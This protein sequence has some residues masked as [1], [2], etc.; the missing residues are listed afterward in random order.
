MRISRITSRRLSPAIEADLEGLAATL[1]EMDKADA[2]RGIPR[3]PS[4]NSWTPHW[5]SALKSIRP[6]CAGRLSIAPILWRSRLLI[7]EP[8]VR[9]WLTLSQ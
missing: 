5:D 2:P 7:F 1:S 3:R 8:R 9:R 4:M 6:S